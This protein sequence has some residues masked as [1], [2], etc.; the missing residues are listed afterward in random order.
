MG[1]RNS[2]RPKDRDIVQIRQRELKNGRTSLYLAYRINGKRYYEYP[3]LYLLPEAGDEA[4]E[5]IRQNK[6]TI[7]LITALK[8]KRLL[9]LTQDR[10]GIS[11]IQERSK[12]PLLDYCASFMEYK[13]RRGKKTCVGIKGMMRYLAGYTEK[14][15]KNYLSQVDKRFCSGFAQYLAETEGPKGRLVPT[16]QSLYFNYFSSCMRK[17]VVDGHLSQNPCSLLEAGEKPHPEQ[18]ERVYLDISEVKLLSMTQADDELAKHAFLFSCFTGLR[19][20]DVQALKWSDISKETDSNGGQRY[21][22]SIRMEKT[23]GLTSFFLSDEALRWL[24][25]RHPGIDVVFPFTES[26]WQACRHV[27]EWCKKAGITKNVTFHSARHTFA[28]MLLTLGADLYTVSKL[29]GHT[30]IRTTQIYAQIVDKKKEEAVS[31]IN[32]FF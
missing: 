21:K 14:T 8:S 3:K 1:N 15:G 19:W 4:A 5:N 17:A 29:L 30:N 11:I 28:T 25:Q 13:D 12:I 7:Q 26:R 31:L 9:E 20:S 2:K 22:L 18:N 32:K 16:T 24:P 27:Q 6:T 23:K 10:S